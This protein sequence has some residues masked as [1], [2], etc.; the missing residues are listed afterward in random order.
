MIL[1]IYIYWHKSPDKTLDCCVPVTETDDSG[2]FT[3]P[4]QVNDIKY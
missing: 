4:P 1:Y 2:Q 3:K